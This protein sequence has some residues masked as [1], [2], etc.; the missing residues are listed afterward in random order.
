M[1]TAHVNHFA[2]AT[3]ELECC[4]LSHGYADRSWWR[5][6]ASASTGCNRSGKSRAKSSSTGAGFSLP[7]SI[8]QPSNSTSPR[9][10]TARD[11]SGSKPISL[12]SSRP[13]PQ[14]SC[15]SNRSRS[16]VAL[17]SMWDPHLYSCARSRTRIVAEP[18]PLGSLWREGSFRD[19]SMGRAHLRRSIMGSGPIWRA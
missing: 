13:H 19:L 7:A 3:P 11:Y 15:G 5:A 6:M 10:T 4:R 17:L 18:R 2:G 12:R 9:A 1:A 8:C 16:P 14:R